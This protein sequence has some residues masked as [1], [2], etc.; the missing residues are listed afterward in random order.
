MKLWAYWFI[1]IIITMLL[2]FLVIVSATC[3]GIDLKFSAYSEL[4]DMS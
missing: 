1:V 3:K 2:Y 4:V